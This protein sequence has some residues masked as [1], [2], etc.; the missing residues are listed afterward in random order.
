MSAAPDP[1]ELTAPRDP[2]S[3]GRPRR[4]GPGVWAFAAFGV[5]C[6]LAGAAIATFGPGLLPARPPAL[7]TM[8]DAA[9]HPGE[10]APITAQTPAPPSETAV[11]PTAPPPLALTRD[12]PEIAA[13]GERLAALEAET[14]E[15]R[16]AAA[17][18]LAAAALVEAS[19]TSRPFAE[20]L[21]AAEAIS[22]PSAELGALRPLAATGAPTRAA[23]AAAFPDYAARAASASRAPDEG[24]GLLERLG[25]A[26]SR[27]VTL[28]RVGEVS[29]DGIDARL[30]RAERQA[31]DGDLDGALKSLDGLP[32]AGREAVAP[33]R[34]RAERRAEVDRR[35]AAVRA[36]ALADLTR[37]SEAG[38]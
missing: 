1:A 7:G 13:L 20:E 25:Y 24:A 12:A 36:R 19:Q 10:P 16:R 29:G 23:L 4:A 37:L 35:V 6:V 21:A 2:A 31:E 18:A 27:V 30:A 28:R 11:V 3:Y 8:A 33:W 38:A 26:L 14:A 5:I 32:A 34:A 17:A 9:L 15:T 22:P